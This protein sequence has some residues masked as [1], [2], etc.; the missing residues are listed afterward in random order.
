[1]I[2]IIEQFPQSLST[3]LAEFTYINLKKLLDMST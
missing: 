3:V 2:S 1:M